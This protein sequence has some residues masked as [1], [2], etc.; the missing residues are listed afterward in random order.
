MAL[1]D[2]TCKNIKP[3]PDKAY[4]LTDEKGLYLLVAKSGGKWWRLDY[5]FNGKRK[6]LSLEP[7]QMLGIRWI[8]GHLPDAKWIRRKI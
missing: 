4:K 1:T 2:T 5:R 6:T 7:I 8:H 3:N